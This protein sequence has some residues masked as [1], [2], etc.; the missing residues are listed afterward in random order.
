[1]TANM[2]LLKCNHRGDDDGLCF[3][4]T[5]LFSQHSC[6]S[7]QESQLLMPSQGQTPKDIELHKAT[8]G[9]PAESWIRILVVALVSLPLC[10]TLPAPPQLRN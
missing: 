3:A 8:S 6:F 1:M 7:L 5:Y 9:E 4:S 10:P 2:N